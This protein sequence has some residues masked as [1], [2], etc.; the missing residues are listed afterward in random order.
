MRTVPRKSW[1]A[2]AILGVPAVGLVLVAVYS[3]E[4]MDVLGRHFPEGAVPQGAIFFALAGLLMT[5]ITISNLRQAASARGW[6]VTRG[7]IVRSEV[8]AKWQFASATRGTRV[9]TYQALVEYRYRVD[10]REYSSRRVRLGAT[11]ASDEAIAGAE[12]ARFPVGAD[13]E[14]HYDP[15]EPD[16]AML[17]PIVAF[18]P[19]TFLLIAVFFGLALY[20]SG[21]GGVGG[22]R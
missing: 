22:V 9:R 7:R 18:K 15:R 5:W 11:V 12:V 10:G 21:I 3:A 4:I 19:L 6:P 2:A 14:V 1:I 17:E 20:F 13:V 16:S 8:E